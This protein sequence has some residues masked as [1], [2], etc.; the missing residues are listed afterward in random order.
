MDRRHGNREHEKER[1]LGARIGEFQTKSDSFVMARVH[2]HQLA[3][4]LMAY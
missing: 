4:S 3:Q 2:V 1:A